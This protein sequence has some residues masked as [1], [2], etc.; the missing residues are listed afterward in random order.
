[1]KT[2]MRYAWIAVLLLLATVLKAKEQQ[3]GYIETSKPGEF[4]QRQTLRP[5]TLVIL[6]LDDT[7]ITTPEGQWLG[8]SE[9]FYDL[10]AQEQ[11][12]YPDKNKADLA[13]VIDTLL[14]AIYWNVPVT[15]TDDAL[16][17]ALKQ[18]IAKGVSVIA[19]TSRGKRTS[20]VTLDQLDQVDIQFT[21][22]GKP[23]WVALDEQRQFRIERNGVVFV[24]HGNKK[25]E[26]LV[27]LLKDGVLN[28]IKHIYLV[29]DRERH[30]QDVGRAL[31]KY[32]PDMHFTPVLCTYLNG[33]KTYN[34]LEAYQQLMTYLI[35]HKDNT[36]IKRL[37]NED[38][39]T[40]EIINNCSSILPER[41][42]ECLSL[43]RPSSND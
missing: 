30:L 21:D 3:A 5:E 27:R 43:R 6:D 18:L 33:K 40:Q 22:L 29:D 41:T 39:Y 35:D 20:E 26:A 2:I 17:S 1:M 42:K 12:K 11:K 25:G 4:L 34:S 28:G 8:R 32:N 24:S 36:V 16:P 19:M 7:T 13:A 31:R 9:M 37:L 14:I 15:V 38:H 23:R 10:L